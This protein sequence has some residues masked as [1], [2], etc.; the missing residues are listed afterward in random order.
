MK[1]KGRLL[2][3]KF[4]DRLNRF[5]VSVSL[6]GRSTFAHLANSGRLR[7]ILLPGVELLVRRA[8]DGSRKTQFDVVLARLDSGGLV[9]VDARLPTPLLQEALG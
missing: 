6:D 2:A 8:P 3:A 5:V 1:L 7:E 4:L 9:S